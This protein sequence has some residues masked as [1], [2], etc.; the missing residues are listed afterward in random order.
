MD[1]QP[2]N[3]VSPKKSS[4]KTLKIILIILIAL[5]IIAFLFY[6]FFV[7]KITN[8]IFIIG[9]SLQ[10]GL[11][12]MTPNSKAIFNQI[13]TNINYNQAD[14]PYLII[15]V[16]NGFPKG[17]P[18]DLFFMA[19]YDYNK[20]SGT[21][22]ERASCSRRNSILNG[23]IQYLNLYV[24]K[25]NYLNSLTIEEANKKFNS[26]VSNCF[27]Y[28]SRYDLQST[29]DSLYNLIDEVRTKVDVSQLTTF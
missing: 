6:H 14:S 9:S 22:L 15:L 20:S 25:N 5:V 12:K 28:L 7:F 11:F 3:I 19:Q 10:T 24:N 13:L 18:Q 21:R 16:K 17:N 23:K 4:H 26:L 1:E 8:K 29:D 27:V 2:L